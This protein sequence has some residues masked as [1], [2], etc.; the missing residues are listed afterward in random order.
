MVALLTESFRARFGGQPRVFFAPG[1]VNL[2]GEHTDYNGGLVMPM[3]PGFGVT[4]GVAP[5]KDRML[6]VY[7]EAFDAEVMLTPAGSP[8]GDWTDYVR[9][10]A[11]EL[12]R[13]GVQ[14]PGVDMTI[15]GDLPLGA[16]LSSSA[17][18]EVAVALALW[19][20]AGAEVEPVRLAK[21]AQRAEN[22]FVGMRCGIMDQLA[23]ACALEG[24][25]VMIDC[26]TLAMQ[27]LPLPADAVIVVTNSM[28]KHALAGS[29]YND[30]RAECER[31]EPKR[32]R[33]VTSENQ[34]VRDAAVALESGDSA[35]FGALMN[36]SHDSLRDDF[37]VSCRE[38]DILVGIA[39]EAGALGSRMT[40]GGFGG[41]TVSLVDK[42]LASAFMDTM[43]E[44]YRA[45]TGLAADTWVCAP[46]RGAHEVFA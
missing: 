17:A 28:V 42:S 16:G 46:A 44:R 26:A 6:R 30:R 2:I 40:G 39:R 25:A 18:L 22:D 13:D 33:H 21:L 4:V 24:H 23:S 29:A 35:R 7:S 3:A 20:L 32:W 5:R 8:R 37:E 45:A 14:V 43:R 12:L 36:A 1:R 38:L 31:R 34:R 10:V 27:H 9:G 19:R 15:H 41:C 11:I